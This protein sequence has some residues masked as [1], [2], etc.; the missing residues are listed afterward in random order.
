M[1]L[2]SYSFS[3]L[4]SIAAGVIIFFSNEK[5]QEHSVGTGKWE[6]VSEKSISDVSLS[7][8]LSLSLSQSSCSLLSLIKSSFLLIT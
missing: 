7:L 3:L 4:H 1:D 2:L 6:C 8:S 5:E